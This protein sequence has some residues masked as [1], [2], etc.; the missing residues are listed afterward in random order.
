M[1]SKVEA[2]HRIPKPNNVKELASYLGVVCYYSR[3]LYG[4][5]DMTEPFKQLLKKGSV[6]T[7]TSACDVAFEEL[8][9]RL[10]SPAVVAHFS[11]THNTFVTCDPSGVAVGAVLSQ[12]LDGVE[13][14]VGFASRALLE[15]ERK[16]SLGEREAIACIWACERWH[17]YLYGRPLMPRTDHQA[18]QTLFTSRGSGHRPLR[19]NGWLDR[20]Y[21]YNFEKEYMPRVNNTVAYFLSRVPVTP[22]FEDS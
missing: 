20:L 10:T 15:N 11:E 22:V 21:Q 1:H 5:A 4:Y 9:R 16:Y 17:T 7:W 2:N 19:L 8:K 18:L 3:F 6:W 14:P 12:L 13:R